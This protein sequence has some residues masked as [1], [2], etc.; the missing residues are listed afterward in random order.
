MATA[1][2]ETTNDA[3]DEPMTSWQQQNKLQHQRLTTLSPVTPGVCN[4]RNNNIMLKKRPS[5]A[6]TEEDDDRHRDYDYS[7]E[8]GKIGYIPNKQ[9]ELHLSSSIGSSSTPLTSKNDHLEGTGGSQQPR[10]SIVKPSPPQDRQ[11][12]RQQQQQHG[13]PQQNQEQQQQQMSQTNTVATS[14]YRPLRK[15]TKSCESLDK[16]CNEEM[17]EKEQLSGEQRSIA[18]NIEPD[19]PAEDVDDS[20]I[21]MDDIKA[22]DNDDDDGDDDEDYDNNTNNEEYHEDEDDVEDEE[23]DIEVG[24]FDIRLDDMDEE[25]REHIIRLIAAAAN[26]NQ[27]GGS[28]PA[29]WI[30]REILQQ[31]R[32]SRGEYDDDEDDGPIEYPFGP[33]LPN[34]LKE[35]AEF[36]L[37]DKCRNILVLAGAGMSVSAGIPDFR[38]ADGLYA[39]LNPDLLTATEEERERIREDPTIALDKHMFL[40]NPLPLLELWREFILGIHDHKWKATIA[41]RFV[42]MLHTKTK[43]LVRLYTQNIDGLED[44][45]TMLPHDKIIAVHG[46]MDRA[47]CERCHHEMD[48][49]RFCQ[50]VKTNVKD[51]SRKDKN[52]PTNSTLIRCDN[53][54]DHTVKPSIVLFRSGLPKVFFES[55]PK[56]ISNDIDLLI[57]MGTSLR[58]APANSIVWRVPRTCMRLLVNRECVGQH[59]G[60]KF[61]DPHV[62]F[63]NDDSSSSNNDDSES[64]APRSCRDYYAS[65]DCDEVLLELIQH[66]GWTDELKPHYE[67]RELPAACMKLLEERRIFDR[68]D[69]HAS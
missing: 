1:T 30:L 51:L 15:K 31:Q 59:L 36:I 20:R 47:D 52:A 69:G 65:G 54:G 4:D 8:D 13:N 12:P 7:V 19:E 68:L 45:C 18:E 55:L 27:E 5:F 67:E 61:P 63:D 23:G 49:H 26:G 64:D 62:D 32:Q 3:T 66:L 28:L 21:D 24:Q 22:D 40:Q 39:T 38:S 44:Q 34:S 43:K 42:E 53:C 48:Y 6:M 10:N 9:N 35:V 11:H 57:V 2:A 41:H 33:K 16:Y 14:Q 25:Q 17:P 46:S 37:S 60:M 50:Y 58:V 56:D 29:S